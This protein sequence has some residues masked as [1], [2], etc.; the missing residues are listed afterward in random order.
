VSI[1][2]MLRDRIYFGSGIGKGLPII[3]LLLALFIPKLIFPFYKELVT[4]LG[5]AMTL[6][7]GLRLLLFH[8]LDLTK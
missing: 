2:K 8:H 3:V 6:V 5:R 1:P 7:L 4:S